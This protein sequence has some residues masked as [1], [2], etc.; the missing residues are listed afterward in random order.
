MNQI[1][2]KVFKRNLHWDQVWESTGSNKESAWY[3]TLIRAA[4]ATAAATVSPEYDEQ[5]Q[6]AATTD[7]VTSL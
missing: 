6:A 4:V 7:I 2:S 5:A 1:G 3:V